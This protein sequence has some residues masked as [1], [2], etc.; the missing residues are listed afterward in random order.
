MIKNQIWM[1]RTIRNAL[2][3][4]L[5]SGDI[6][7]EAIIPPEIEGK[8]VLE[9]REHMVLA[10]LPV[11]C[12]VFELVGSNI[13]FSVLFNDSQTVPGGT[14]ICTVTGP[15]SAILKGERTALNFIQRMSCIKTVPGL[16]HFDK[17][18]VRMGGGSNH[19]IGLFDGI[20]IKDNHIAVAGSISRAVELAKDNAPHTIKM[21]VEVEVENLTGVEEAVQAGA[22]II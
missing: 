20:L 10:G 19:R 7:T 11:F 15:L 22:D 8:A 4:D 13:S 2:E 21:E 1:D 5:G 3:E 18:A 17:Y 14:Q 9:A 16:R 6:T 12:R